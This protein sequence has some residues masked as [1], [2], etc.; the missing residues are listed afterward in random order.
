MRLYSKKIWKHTEIFPFPLMILN[1]KHI[2]PF[3][4]L[5]YLVSTSKQQCPTSI[6]AVRFYEI[7]FRFAQLIFCSFYFRWHCCIS[8]S[9]LHLSQHCLL[10]PFVLLVNI[11][12]F[13]LNL[14]CK[15]IK[16]YSGYSWNL[17]I[18]S[19]EKIK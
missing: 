10:S 7:A 15:R 11:P 9:L 14:S 13:I 1:R 2:Y 3:L 8:L 6:L 5:L 18:K 12:T 17:S 16:T 4:K 19:P